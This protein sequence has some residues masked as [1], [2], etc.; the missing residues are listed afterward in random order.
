MAIS[1]LIPVLLL[2]ALLAASPPGGDGRGPSEVALDLAG[3]SVVTVH[4][5]LE[6]DAG[7][8]RGLS[9]RI[10]QRTGGLFVRADGLVLVGN[11]IFPAEGESV[12][13]S[14][15]VT[16]FGVLLGERLL[17]ARLAGRDED[18]GLAFLQVEETGPFPAV[19]L[20]GGYLPELGEELLAVG[21]LPEQYDH[22]PMVRRL[23]VAA[24]L[25]SGRWV[26]DGA[27]DASLLAAPLLTLDGRA[28][29]VIGIEP[30][31]E[32]RNP[33][34]E[35]EVLLTFLAMTGPGKRP[36][37]PVGIP[38]GE[39]APSLA[40]PPPFRTPDKPAWIGITL[41]PVSRDLAEHWKLPVSSGIAVTSVVPGSPAEV[42]G[43]EVGDVMVRFDGHPV[44]AEQDYELQ[45]FIDMV[46]ETGVGSEVDLVVY[47][48]G[49]RRKV[50]L[51]LV[52][53][54]VSTRLAETWSSEE[55][56]VKVRELTFDQIQRA[57]LDPEI[58]GVV[59][60]ELE[61]GGWAQVGGLATG[62]VVLRVGESLVEDLDGFREVL[63]R[64][65]EEALAEVVF[66]VQ[67]GHETF[68]VPVQ[69][70][71]GP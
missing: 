61:P 16:E 17:P 6:R 28:V 35:P 58:R 9:R 1:R 10:Q 33:E 52:E 60:D 29:G 40:D 67:R 57:N 44:R 62:D 47:R 59:V 34:D 3:T 49:R 41:Q 66:F 27:M 8:F 2:P 68:F 13:T 25:P 18:A 20:T 53:A 70:D 21:R 43:I 63:R 23:R 26:L 22:A 50:S 32:G 69:T 51:R 24:F 4:Y 71:Y 64:V 5:V 54:P 15:R 31:P 46:R 30:F 45:P 65:K 19:E 48:G 7:E 37:L 14:A 39:I 42:A 38:T 12:E 11:E 56:G 55:F 36:G